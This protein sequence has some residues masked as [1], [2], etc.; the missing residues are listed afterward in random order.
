MVLTLSHSEVEKLRALR[1]A[2]AIIDTDGP[3]LAR[4][5]A[6]ELRDLLSTEGTLVYT[7][8]WEEAGWAVDQFA[9]SGIG[10]SRESTL[11]SG[12]EAWIRRSEAPWAYYDPR[13]VERPQ[14]NKA[15]AVGTWRTLAENQ[16][17]ATLA[18]AQISKEERLRRASSVG[19][20]RPWFEHWGTVD[21]QQLRVIV[22]DGGQMLGWVGG[23]Q[24]SH[25]GGNAR[26]LLA[27]VV[28][29]L[30]KRF[31][32]EAQ[33]SGSVAHALIPA[34][35]DGIPTAAYVLDG[36]DRVV[37]CNAIG[38][39]WLAADPKRAE[40][41]RAAR[42]RSGDSRFTVTEIISPGV[43]RHALAIERPGVPVSPP[44][45]AVAVRFGLTKRETDI[46]RGLAEV[47]TNRTIAGMLGCSERTV[48]THVGRILAKSDCGSRAALIATVWTLV[49]RA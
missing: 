3:P 37:T 48:E 38:R 21:A 4:W 6:D 17:P 19:D 5:L 39:E 32:L 25:F 33:L 24:H 22:C 18:K 11:R 43:T 34:L 42:R 31:A 29:P 45:T 44:V 27:R 49:G 20:A 28:A 36:R 46:L 40:L 23:L 35:L 9:V 26:Q 13:R 8:R 15:L 12:F 10:A 2:L 41:L 14:R 30:R 1:R 47:R 7:P 16:L